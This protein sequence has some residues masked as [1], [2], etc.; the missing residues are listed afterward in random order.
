MCALKATQQRV[1]LANPRSCR[2]HE[3]NAHTS[4]KS[5]KYKFVHMSLNHQ[6][7]GRHPSAN[8]THARSRRRADYGETILFEALKGSFDDERI[9]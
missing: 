6:S 8:N 1:P 5:H 2:V 4:H 3:N 9:A 7:S